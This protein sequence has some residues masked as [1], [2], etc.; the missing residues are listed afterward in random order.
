MRYFRIATILT[1]LIYYFSM[2]GY[3]YA[4][5]NNK[6][7]HPF[8]MGVTGGYG[9]TT[10]EGLVPP[11]GKQNLAMAMSTPIYVSEGGALWGLFAGYEFLP[12][13][14][15]EVSY[16]RYPNAKVTFDEMSIFTF[17]LDGIT[18]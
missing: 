6:V 15:L 9:R 16:L 7:K 2:N 17:M 11:P 1:A 14:A 3:V 18:S 12:S 13:F 10:W 4:E 5:I 8:Y